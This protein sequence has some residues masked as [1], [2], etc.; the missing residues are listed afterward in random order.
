MGVVSPPRISEGTVSPL[1]S[2][3]GQGSSLYLRTITTTHRWPISGF[4]G[5]DR[6]PSPE[7]NLDRG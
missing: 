3:P 6:E 4:L 1:G 7:G 2:S 5:R